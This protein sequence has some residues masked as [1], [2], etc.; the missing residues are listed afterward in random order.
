MSDSPNIVALRRAIQDAAEMLTAVPDN[1][2]LVARTRHLARP[3]VRDNVLTEGA[4]QVLTFQLGTGELAARYAWPIGA[5]HGLLHVEYLTP[6]PSA[7]PVY[8]G[9]I[10]WRGTI[11]AALDLRVYFGQPIPAEPSPWVMVIG[12][13]RFHNGLK[14]G[15]LADDVFDLTTLQA[16]DVSTL[17]DT[18][19]ALI[20]GIT[21]DKLMLLD[22]EQLLAREVERAEK[23]QA[24]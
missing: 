20:A 9:L 24:I 11:L 21:A 2:N 22:A 8:R 4:R 18:G 19:G 10:N 14:V 16:A 6:I 23:S 1:E 7:P 5:V 13:E 12:S 17:P 3:L 15:V